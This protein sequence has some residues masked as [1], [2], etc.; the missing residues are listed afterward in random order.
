VT[1]QISWSDGKRSH[2][3]RAQA[4]WLVVREQGVP[5]AEVFC[6]SY[7]LEEKAQGGREREQRPVTFLF[8]GGPG[9]ASAF[10]HLGTAGPRRVAFGATGE[11]LPPPAKL[12]DNRESWLAFTDL[13]FVDPVG[14]GLS[15]TVAVSRLEQAGVP[16]EGEPEKLAKQS[17]D[18]PE[19]GKPF[20]K[21]KR[22]IDVLC[23]VVGQWLSEHNRWGSA[24]SI[25]GESYGGFRV[26]KL[27]RALPERGIGLSGAVMVSPAIDFLTLIGGDYEPMSW[28]NTL[29]TMARAARHHGV[30]RGRYKGMDPDALGAAAV[31]F[32]ELRLAPVLL[33]GERASVKE[34]ADVLGELADMTGLSA[35]LVERFNG[36]VSIGAFARELLRGRGL[37]CGLYDASL[38]GHNVFPDREGSPNPDPTLAGIMAVFNVGVNAVLRGE[39]GLQTQREY[40]LFSE[41]AWKGWADDRMS[42]YWHRQLECADDLRYGLG[43]NPALKLLITHGHFDLVTT[44][45][46]SAQS[47]ALMRLPP[48]LRANVTL[49]NY[50]GG[51]MFYTWQ[52][53]HKA[54]FGDARAA[55][56]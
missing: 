40:M 12:E 31:D 5:T 34:R 10:L 37:I 55:L 49:K 2:R 3:V 13:V 16:L 19:A 11:V 24:V 23:E 42:G 28:I 39:L 7:Q 29:P 45:H 43:M 22:D 52:A 35:E 48:A 56:A 26:G 32:A 1:K 20:F 8:N 47:V 18:A 27:A 44:Y 53:S 50:D 36:R 4:Q 54:L 38:T 33:R 14:T 6:V 15:R 25:A 46:S 51:H 17:K 41:E 30:A 9:A 21:V